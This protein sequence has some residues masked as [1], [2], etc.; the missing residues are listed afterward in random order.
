MGNRG[1]ELAA[2]SR[3]GLT[4]LQDGSIRIA[5][6]HSFLYK[7]Q[8]ADRAP[9]PVLVHPLPRN[10]LCPVANLDQYFKLSKNRQGLLFIHPKIGRTLSRGQI[11]LRA[12]SLIKEADPSGVPQMHDL[13]R[14]A[15]SIAWTRGIPPAQI[16]KVLSGHGRTPLSSDTC[17]NAL[18]QSV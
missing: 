18:T 6:R 10:Q 8:T 14:A 16:I 7:N 1:A 4:H 2:F 12:C 11:A 3:E 5:T 17:A 15:A 9:P 13:R